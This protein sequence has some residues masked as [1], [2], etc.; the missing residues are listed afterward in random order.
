MF[1]ETTAR[2]SHLTAGRPMPIRLGSPTHLIC[3]GW[4][5][6]WERLATLCS[7]GSMDLYEPHHKEC[8]RPV[9][10]HVAAPARTCYLLF[11]LLKINASRPWLGNLMTNLLL[12]I[13]NFSQYYDEENC[14][15]NFIHTLFEFMS[16]L[17]KLDLSKTFL[18]ALK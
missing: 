2:E 9:S 14:L 12:L 15:I 5:G 10:L 8:K 4:S 6:D 11:A 18:P 17:F 16:L 13:L 1:T 7:L 3:G